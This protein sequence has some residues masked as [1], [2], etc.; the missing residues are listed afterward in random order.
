M[1][2]AP[3]TLLEFAES[4]GF[5]A[6]LDWDGELQIE[7]PLSLNVQQVVDILESHSED[8]SR[9]LQNRA[10]VE[11]RQFV[12]GP[13]NGKPHGQLPVFGT[14]RPLTVHLGR[15]RWAVYV[16]YRD[17]RAPFVGM[18]TSRKKAL[19]QAAESIQRR[20]ATAP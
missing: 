3:R 16:Q 4:L 18:S 17:G 12:G 15:G 10:S 7:Q 13:L 2:I 11:R 1:K 14:P 8:V 19:E 6:S 5:S 20:K 9:D